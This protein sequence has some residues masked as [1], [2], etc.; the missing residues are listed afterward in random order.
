MNICPWLLKWLVSRLNVRLLFWNLDLFWS[1]YNR[2]A[3]KN[4][5]GKFKIFRWNVKP[6]GGSK[7]NCDI[8]G[9][10]KTR[11][12]E[13]LRAKARGVTRHVISGLMWP[14]KRVGLGTC[15]NRAVTVF[16][17]WVRGWSTVG[18]GHGLSPS[19]ATKLAVPRCTVWAARVHPDLAAAISLVVVL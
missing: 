14:C 17:A 5:I 15:C 8:Q 3:S 18:D 1:Q 12:E 10:W 7:S 19:T 6:N 9:R 16:H 4:L 11:G 13:T 2:S